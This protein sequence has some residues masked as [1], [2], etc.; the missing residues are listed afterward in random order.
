ME[1]K[2]NKIV[3]DIMRRKKIMRCKHYVMDRLNMDKEEKSREKI[4]LMEKK[5]KKIKIQMKFT[6][7]ELH[8]IYKSTINNL[9]SDEIIDKSTY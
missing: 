5:P 9:N 6:V 3:N 8:F 2:K 4:H 1:K 7:N